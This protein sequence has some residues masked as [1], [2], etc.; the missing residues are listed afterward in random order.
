MTNLQH[1][2]GVADAMLNGI[3]TAFIAT[4]ILSSIGLLLSLYVKKEQPTR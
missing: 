3:R 2:L 4:T 1:E